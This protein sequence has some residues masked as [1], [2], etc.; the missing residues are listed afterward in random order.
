MF[1]HYIDS[2]LLYLSPLPPS[3]LLFSNTTLI[4][5]ANGPA[6]KQPFVMPLP[7]LACLAKFVGSSS[8]SLRSTTN[9]CV[10]LGRME[11]YQPPLPPPLSP[12]DLFMDESHDD[13]KRLQA[14]RGGGVSIG[15]TW[16]DLG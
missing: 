8:R 4:V 9:A 2:I 6:A 11:A 3:S 12:F 14:R 1:L 5:N 15:G 16:E 13:E 10:R 7:Y